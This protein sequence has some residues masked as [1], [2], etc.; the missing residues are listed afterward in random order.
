MIETAL[1][2][3]VCVCFLGRPLHLCSICGWRQMS[4][5]VLRGRRPETLT[6]RRRRERMTRREMVKMGLFVV[7]IEVHAEQAVPAQLVASL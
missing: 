4:S 3:F 5:L 1:G 7:R 6:R 2:G